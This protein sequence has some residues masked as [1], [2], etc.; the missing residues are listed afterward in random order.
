MSKIA[1][2]SSRIFFVP[3]SALA[4]LFDF[5]VDTNRRA[6]ALLTLVSLVAFLPGF[7]QIPPIDRDEPRYAQATKQ[8]LDTGDFVDIRF[9]DEEANDKPVGIYWAQ[10]AAVKAVEALGVPDARSLIWPYRL[11]SLFGAIGAVMGTYWCAL[12]FVGRRGAMLAAL[13]M[14]GSTLLGVEARLAKT[15]AVLLFNVVVAMGALARVYLAIREA[16]TT[17]PNFALLATFWTAFA[18]GILVKGLLIVMIVVL[19]TAALAIFDR[20]VRWLLALRPLPGIV[21]SAVLVLPW[22]VAISRR[23]GSAFLV[24]SVGKDT[25]GKILNSQQ[26]H[27]APP[28]LYFVLFFVTFFPASILAGLAAPA[29]TMSALRGEPAARFLLAWLV[30]SWI[31]FELAVTK[32]PHYVLPLYPAI[33]I[34]LAGAVESGVLSQRRW[35]LRGVIWW[36]LVPVIAA[37]AVIVGAITIGHEPLFAA[38][39]FLAAAVACGLLAWRSYEAFGAERAF[40]CATAAWMLIAIA[41][42]ALVVPALGPLFPSPA[43]ARVLRDSGC[44]HPVAASAGYEEPSLV[45]LAGTSIQLT[46]PSGAADFLLQGSCHFAFID[47]H[48]EP[49]FAARAEAIGLRYDRGPPIEALNLGHVQPV[50]I[51]VM[52]SKSALSLREETVEGVSRSQPAQARA[53]TDRDRAGTR[54]RVPVCG[55]ECRQKTRWR[56]RHTDRPRRLRLLHANDRAADHHAA[57]DHAGS[58]QPDLKQLLRRGQAQ[59]ATGGRRLRAHP[60]RRDKRPRRSRR[61]QDSRQWHWHSRRGKG[62]D[63]QS[64]LHHKARRRGYRVGLVHQP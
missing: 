36:F 9:Q 3:A 57:G 15:D 26:G 10:A 54:A 35:L 16:E 17:R 40:L 37:I 46:G 53:Q 23:T 51:A 6:V 27:G 24:G 11:P 32:L 20:S 34:L 7:L 61:N 21:W 1:S 5:C 56:A 12:A 43:L 52:R 25:L 13:M 63:V 14:A 8:M 42:Y 58:A 28:G 2:A 18:L 31:V 55:R 22:I 4:A 29:V 45:F 39:P 48:Q 30:P 62:K 60:H 50:T 44:A 64:F 19:A 49:A 41:T 38:W 33:A 59:G 47:E